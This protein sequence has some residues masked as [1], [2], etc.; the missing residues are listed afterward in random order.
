MVTDTYKLINAVKKMYPVVQFFK[1]RYFPDG[2]VYYSEKAL[3]ET[4]IASRIHK[5]WLRFVY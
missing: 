4:K 1:N 2:K 3:V 5:S